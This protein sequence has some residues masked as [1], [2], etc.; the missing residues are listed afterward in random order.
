VRQDPCLDISALAARLDAD[1][2]V[3][4]RGGLG[5]LYVVLDIVVDGYL[6]VL[7][8]LENDVDEI[9]DQVFSGE[10]AVARRIYQLS[11]EVIGLR[12]A[13]HPLPD[14]LRRAGLA[15][16]AHLVNGEKPA[17][18][19]DLAPDELRAGL[20]DVWDH[21]G[22]VTER[23]DSLHQVVGHILE[24]NAT[25]VTLEQNTRMASLA[26]QQFRQ[27]AQVK[28]ISSWAAIFLAPTLLAGMWGM[29]FEV[30]PELR[31]DFG[32]PAALVTMAVTSTALYLRFKRI[33]WL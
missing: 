22:T 3:T 25:L 12:R 11:R 28:K 21:V 14:V 18:A 27:D 9:E 31:W 20:A 32:Y 29:N 8:G 13:V 24:T 19:M 15:M 10:S 2:W 26:E 17:A 6:P 30:M 7:D 1:P 5:V 33:N 4:Q 23:T 16:G